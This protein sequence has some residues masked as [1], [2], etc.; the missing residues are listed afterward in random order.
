MWFYG[1]GFGLRAW[2]SH[3]VKAFLLMG[4]LAGCTAMVSA[5]QPVAAVPLVQAPPLVADGEF[6]AAGFAPGEYLVRAGQSIGPWNVD[7]GNVGLHVGQVAVPG[8]GMNVVDLNG[9]R[10]G[11]L[12][13]TLQLQRGTTYTLRFLLT[14]NWRTN[15]TT[16]RRVAVLFGLQ[17]QVFEVQPP[18]DWSFENPQ[19]QVI[20]TTFTPSANAVGLRFSSENPGVPDGAM[21]TDVEVL[22]PPVAPGPLD[23][24]PIPLPPDLDDY[25]MDR[26]KAVLLGKALFWDMQVGSD[27]RTAC[28]TCHWHAG[29][30]IRTKHT[31]S[32]GAPGSQF[33]HQTDLGDALEAKALAG[34]RGVNAQTRP[35]DYP[36][37]RFANPLIPGDEP[38]FVNRGNP[39]I[40]D[41]L[42]VHGSAGIRKAKFKGI[43]PGSAVD[44][45]LVGADDDEIFNIDGANVR[46]VTGRN[47][48]TSINAVFF[49]RTFWDGRA[50]NY[51]NGVN[52]F[53]DLDPDARVLKVDASGRLQRVR[54]LL[55]N[56]SLASQ[57]VGPVNSSAEM[58]WIAREFPDVAR[59]LFSLRPLALQQVDST[60]SVLGLWVDSSGRGLDAEKAGYARL[61]RE[62]FRPEWWSSQEITSGGYTQMEANFSLFW[63]LSLMLYQSTLV[64][65]QAP[66]DQFAKGDLNAL[67]P[68]AKEG[69]R[70][71]LNEGKCIN[72]HG[73]PQFAGALV[74]EVRGA[75]GEG[76]IEFMPMA[77][78]AAFY[79]GGFYNIG[80][81][82]TAEDIGVGASHPKFG[83]LSY[84]RQ[85]QQGRN[86][87]ER[88]IVRPR[89][90]V[91]VD[92]AFKSS[93]LRNIELT[94]PYMH[95][96]GMKSLE[97]V[98]QF[99]TRGAD[100]ERTNRRDLDPDVGGIPELQGNP[101]KISAVVEFMLHL[102]DPRVKYRKAP[103][104]H[105]ELVL[106]QGVSGVV[107]GFARDILY[108]LPAVG[109]DGGAPFGTF[110]D[111]LKYG[112]PLERLNQ[113][114]MI[115]PE[116][117]G[118]RMQ[119]VAGEPVIDV[120]V[121]PG[122]VKP[123]VVIDPA[124]E[125]VAADPAVVDP[126]AADPAVAEPVAA[127]PAVAEPVAA[128][129]VVAEPL[130][131]K[132]P[133]GV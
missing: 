14:G 74:N 7:L 85:E 128:D 50:N 2:R 90:R 73:G 126:A 40:F 59:K 83:P 94:G 72:C 13:Q 9:N 37:H 105:P 42:E 10:G 103:F 87:D 51:F 56:A 33:G 133:A 92:G 75:A 19:W 99:Y 3:G 70:I 113:T 79:D 67:T 81:R 18:A 62:A 76:L 71:F 8:P 109:R 45:I 121:P 132:L 24:E 98:V 15:P 86:P 120:G 26:Q 30:D 27:G 49:D 96:G 116:S 21:I 65:D 12:F 77:V 82:P 4:A 48:P 80:V 11:S 129:P 64:S 22:P 47:A 41:T 106:P 68:K 35:E 16:P 115:A 69:L 101:E 57:A 84:S 58:S 104:D 110:E 95:N 112:F 78:G 122:D 6:A 127:D 130:P 107:D 38:G 108:L 111:A 17:R 114:Q 43:I 91:A 32:P 66:Y 34:F 54:I 20:E 123:P 124:A 89:D 28:A 53:G 131:P 118:R 23:A 39:V 93:T 36:F 100:F 25:V 31:L 125:P 97:E 117:T 119:P 5:Q 88:V 61:V 55:R 63:G 29:A 60:D 102:T 46:Q 52:P 1:H 44:E